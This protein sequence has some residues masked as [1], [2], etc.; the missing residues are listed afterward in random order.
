[1]PRMIN[2]DAKPKNFGKVLRIFLSDLKSFRVLIVASMVLTVISVVL[3]LFGPMLLGQITTEAVTSFMATGAIAWPAIVTIVI[4]LIILYV[5]S[6]ILDYIQGV[7]L[8]IA[9]ERYG[10]HLRNQIIE[11]IS[12][13]PI[14]YFD[15]NQFGDTLSRMSNDEKN[16]PKGK[17][18]N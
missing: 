8:S 7:M 6:A 17:C 13:L 16:Q 9:T 15:R 14:A 4:K 1:M 10:K 11:K 3:R 2:P 18:H 12:H 5:S